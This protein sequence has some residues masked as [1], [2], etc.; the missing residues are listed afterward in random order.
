MQTGWGYF[1]VL[2]EVGTVN[3][4][5]M[6]CIKNA[7]ILITSSIVPIILVFL[8]CRHISRII[9]CA[10]LG[11]P[12]NTQDKIKHASNILGEMF[13]QSGKGASKAVRA[14]KKGWR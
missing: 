2:A 13:V 7:E 14:F 1:I 3:L 8:I 4:G 9:S 12:R 5:E 10:G 11:L 6:V